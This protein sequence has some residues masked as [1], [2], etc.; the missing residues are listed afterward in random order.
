MHEWMNKPINEWMNELL[1]EGHT[2]EVTNTQDP[3]G[4]KTGAEAYLEWWVRKYS[5]CHKCRTCWICKHWKIST[6]NYE[7][8][9]L[10]CF[11][12]SCMT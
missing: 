12:S 4:S 11:C 8:S 7:C 5:S 3:I 2:R 1:Y 6:L 10:N 9:L